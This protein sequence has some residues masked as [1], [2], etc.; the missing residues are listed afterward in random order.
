[1]KIT[2]SI[3][4]TDAGQ[5]AR[6]GANAFVGMTFNNASEAQVRSYCEQLAENDGIVNPSIV[7]TRH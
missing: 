6:D 3:L 2:A 4:R 5:I 1:M 7:I